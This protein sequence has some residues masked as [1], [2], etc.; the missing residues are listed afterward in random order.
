MRLD[1]GT[2]AL[3]T[4]CSQSHRK[5]AC[6]SAVFFAEPGAALR[7]L[8]LTGA[9]AVGRTRQRINRERAS[10]E[11]GDRHILRVGAKRHM[12]HRSAKVDTHAAEEDPKLVGNHSLLIELLCSLPGRGSRELNANSPDEVSLAHRLRTP[13]VTRGKVNIPTVESGEAGT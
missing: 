6:P 3:P 5:F 9:C 10:H 8:D 4:G 2:V 1:R 11:E 7:R 12:V 13:P